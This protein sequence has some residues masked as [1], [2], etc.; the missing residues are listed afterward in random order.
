MVTSD[1]KGL[2]ELFEELAAGNKFENKFLEER[3]VFLWGPV[4]D[5]SAKYVVERLL[6]LDSIAPGKEIT[7]LINSPGGVVTS[8]MI[9]YDTMQM[10][11][12]PVATVCMGLAASM[13][14]ILLS[15]G[16]KGRRFIF[17]HGRVMIH[18]P[19]IGGVVQG[20]ASDIAITAKEIIK[21]KELGAKIL[22]ENCGQTVEKIMKDFDRDYWM[23]AEESVAY[24][25]VDKIIDKFEW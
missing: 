7:L 19:S 6:Y 13:G 20:Q 22:A 21:T 23:N 16:A 3:K 14:S 2:R 25:I 24:G 10:I 5:Q 4:T 11:Q 12:S 1:S 9:I 15:G 8:G 18:Q 17:P